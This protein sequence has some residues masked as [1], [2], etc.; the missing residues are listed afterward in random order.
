[1]KKLKIK[2]NN[3]NYL[4]SIIKKYPTISSGRK[5][6]NSLYLRVLKNILITH[7]YSFLIK[8]DISIK[9]IKKIKFEKNKNFISIRDY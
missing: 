8:K 6:Y 7:H 9:N 3:Q 5:N 2:I 4:K 1:M